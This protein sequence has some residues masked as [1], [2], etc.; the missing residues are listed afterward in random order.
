[1]AEHPIQASDG[2]SR[3]QNQADAGLET[4]WRAL[5][6]GRAGSLAAAFPRASA[7]TLGHGA[8][9]GLREVAA[10]SPAAVFVRGASNGWKPAPCLDR[11]SYALAALYLDVCA[12]TDS[13]YLVGHLGQSLDGFVATES[14][15]SDFVTGP[16]NI[17][18]LHRM[19]ALCSAVIVGA[20]TVRLDD[21]QL[22]TRLVAG[23]NPL[24]VLAA[25]SCVIARSVRSWL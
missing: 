18:H 7:L 24:L 15:D 2:L 22:T 6:A 14:G 17:L 4:T 9:G 20:S 23:P 8:A 3:T 21:P 11:E 16:E 12:A 13:P 10:D 25:L 19:R 1:M 5:F